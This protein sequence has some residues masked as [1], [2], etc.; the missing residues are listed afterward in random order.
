[1]MLGAF[2]VDEVGTGSDDLNL[3][4]KLEL[5]TRERGWGVGGTKPGF[6]Q[7]VARSEV[8]D[9]ESTWGPFTGKAGQRSR[10]QTSTPS[11][12]E[13]GILVLLRGPGR[14]LDLPSK[15]RVAWARSALEKA[16]YT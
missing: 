6:E 13:G 1:M 4:G 9:V 10:G 12:Q 5:Q 11:E 7:E 2:K 14:W 8:I 15:E 16:H 3:C